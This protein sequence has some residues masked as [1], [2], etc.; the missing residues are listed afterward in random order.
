MLSKS[1]TTSLPPDG[2]PPP[3][4][5]GATKDSFFRF[6]LNAKKDVI[7]F[8]CQGPFALWTVTSFSLLFFFDLLSF[9]ERPILAAPLFS[10][11]EW[12]LYPELCNRTATALRFVFSP[13]TV[14]PLFFL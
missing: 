2:S 14:I 3:R 5:F 12:R 13:P 8:L 1:A 6:S 10:M 11:V 7:S 4:F 9:P